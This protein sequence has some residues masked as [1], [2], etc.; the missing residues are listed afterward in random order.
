MGFQVFDAGGNLLTSINLVS[1]TFT[2]T[3][4]LSALTASEL[5]ATNAS[6]GLVSL[7][8]ATYPSLT[9]L[10]Y[11]KGVTSAIQTQFGAKV[12]NSLLTTQGDLP[13]A[14]GASTW[15]GLAKGTA[16]QLL[17]MNAGATAPEWASTLAGLTLTSPTINGTI[18][19]TGLT[20]PAVTLAGL[21]NANG[22][23]IENITALKG[24]TT[25]NLQIF[26]NAADQYIQI[27]SQRTAAN[28]GNCIFLAT[29][30]G[31]DVISN[32]LAISGGVTTAVATWANITHTGLVLGGALTLNGQAFDAGAG[33]GTVQS[34]GSDAFVVKSTN[35]GAVGSRLTISHQGGSPAANDYIGFLIFEGQNSTPALIDYGS[36]EVKSGTVTASGEVSNFEFYLMAAGSRNAAM[37]LTGAGGLSV[38]ADIGTADDPVALFD[39]YDDAL[40]LKNAIQ[41]RNHELLADMGIF[42]RKETGSGYMM[43]LQPMVRLLAGG[44]Y[45]SRELIETTREEFLN[46]VEQLESKLMLLEAR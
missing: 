12:N 40:V 38:D 44:I 28:A 24:R 39:S 22:Q 10:A 15:A 25:G 43:N 32:R 7:A 41:H 29:M 6:K 1:P 16:N 21:V 13:Y 3:V 11:V 26:D 19:T 45:Q 37:A 35:S 9:E 30:S 17:R 27:R 18:A 4:T 2:G 36:I 14:I 5:V 20:L 31:A 8:V 23:N 33:V 34:T 46:R 42:S